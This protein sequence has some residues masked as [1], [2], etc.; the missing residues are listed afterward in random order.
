MEK[1]FGRTYSTVGDTSADFIIK[2]RGDIK[3]QVNHNFITLVKGGKLNVDI[4]I[5]KKVASKDRIY[6]DGIYVTE[7]NGSVYVKI[8]D[9]L[10]ALVDGDDCTYVSYQTEQEVNSDQQSLA[11]KNIGLVFDTLDEAKE[12]VQKGFVYINEE[13]SFYTVADGMFNKLSFEIPNPYPKQIVINNVEETNGAIKITG[14]NNAI[15]WDDHDFIKYDGGMTFISDSAFIY[16]LGGNKTIEITPTNTVINNTL[17]TNTVKSTNYS[18][19]QGFGLYNKNSESYLEVDNLIVRKGIPGVS[20]NLYPSYYDSSR[21][22]NVIT[23]AAIS[24]EDSTTLYLTLKYCKQYQVG[25]TI[26]SSID[27]ISEQ[28]FIINSVDIDED[29]ATSNDGYNMLTVKCTDTTFD[30]ERYQ[31]DGYNKLIFLRG[32]KE[33][34]YNSKGIT[35]Q[36]SNTEDYVNVRIGIINKLK[37]DSDDELE[38][39]DIKT[40]DEGDTVTVELPKDTE[41]IY[42]DWFLAVKAS[43][44]SPKLYDIEFKKTTSG[45]LKYYPRIEEGWL[46]D[47]DD[48]SQKLITSKWFWERKATR[49]KYGIVKLHTLTITSNGSTL[50]TF[51]MNSDAI[52]D[53]GD[54]SSGGTPTPSTNIYGA[55]FQDDQGNSQEY[56]PDSDAATIKFK[57]TELTYY[58]EGEAKDTIAKITPFVENKIDI[59]PYI[60]GYSVT[61]SSAH[62]VVLYAGWFEKSTTAWSD[63]GYKHPLV[64]SITISGTKG[65]LTVALNSSKTITIISATANMRTNGESHINNADE[66]E[67]RSAAACISVGY[68]G[69]TLYLKGWR[70]GNE[71]ND[72]SHSNAL[73]TMYGSTYMT[74]SFITSFTL[75]VIGFMS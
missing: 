15:N 60:D 6:S 18:S 11:Q 51:N 3:V 10:I 64:S 50:G 28:S 75:M 29:S 48:N 43:L 73:N 26:Y 39:I 58:K 68:S 49:E 4:D 36:S 63:H 12:K 2:T 27:G 24:D 61:S 33:R 65:Y 70:F 19:T 62:M 7:D 20:V 57:T 9:Q 5:V 31:E 41:G 47:D 40:K 52:I 17:K 69:S 46:L 21:M 34:I 14:D 56:N 44:V 53:V 72:T 1:F 22:N 42:A 23:N 13:Q 35:I 66:D 16:Y 37:K 55:T 32:E 25:Q 38:S 74:K 45:D 54:G 67:Y 30:I 71:D 8:G 59:T